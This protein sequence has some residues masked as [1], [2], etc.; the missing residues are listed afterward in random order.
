VETG[1]DP[2]EKEKRKKRKIPAVVQSSVVS[3][4]IPGKMVAI[5]RDVS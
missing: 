2:A 1:F 4:S 5:Q 3:G